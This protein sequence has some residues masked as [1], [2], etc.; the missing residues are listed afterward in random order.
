M[1]NLALLLNIA[2][3]GHSRFGPVR[4]GVEIAIDDGHMRCSSLNICYLDFT[5]CFLFFRH[6]SI[7]S[8]G[9]RTL[10]RVPADW[11]MET[12]V[13]CLGLLYTINFIWSFCVNLKAAT[14]AAT[15]T[16]V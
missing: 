10:E 14:R 3:V 8:Y 12:C 11:P 16:V 9:R 7:S 4:G 1:S 2:F 15:N 5:F 13:S 6:T